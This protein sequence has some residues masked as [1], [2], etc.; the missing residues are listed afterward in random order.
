MYLIDSLI[1]VVRSLKAY[2]MV[3]GSKCLWVP[4]H[5][6]PKIEF[7]DPDKAAKAEADRPA[8]LDVLKRKSKSMPIIL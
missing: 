4:Q 1:V 2:L 5:E 7:G 3:K 8:Q 6:V